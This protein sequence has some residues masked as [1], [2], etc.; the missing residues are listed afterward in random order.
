MRSKMILAVL[1]D[2][3]FTV[4]IH[5]L[6]KRAGLTVEFLKSEHDVLQKAKEHPPSLII[7]DLN[8][9]S[10]H[11]VDL[12]SKLK[13]Q[14]ETRSIRLLAYVSHV[15]AELKQKAQEAGCDTVLARSAFSTNLPAIL[16]RHGGLL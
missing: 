3:M 1:D 15:N 14:E 8:T 4:K 5:D 7:I 2:L 12:I 9:R 16:K 13:E 10:V 6:A 11:P